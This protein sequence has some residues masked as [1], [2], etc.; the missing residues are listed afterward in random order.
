M[1]GDLKTKVEHVGPVAVCSFAGDLQMET[2][3]QVRAA[4]NTALGLSPQVL[5]VD[6]AGAELF[7]SSGLNALLQARLD[8]A[9]LSVPVVLLAPS[10]VVR[11]VLEVTE[12]E[13]LFPVCADAR[14][15]VR[16]APTPQAPGA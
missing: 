12:A 1:P 3:A 5:A 9:D 8:A 6:L 4:L 15:A 7:T 10:R 2:E 13:G 14:E 11:R 16:Y